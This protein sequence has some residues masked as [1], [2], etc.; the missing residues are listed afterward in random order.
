MSIA[1][2]EVA[3]P[4]AQAL[5]SIAKSK[6][7]TDELNQT[8]GEFLN[9]LNE[10]SD[11]SQFLAN[12]IAEK[13]AKRGVINKVLGDGANQQ[14]KNFMMLL[15]DKGR[16]ALVQPILEEFRSLVREMN[17]TV[18]AEVISAV[19]LTD[20][21]KETVRQKVQGMTDAKSVELST[22]VDSDLI[23]GVIVK[24]GSKVLDAS[25]RGQLRRISLQ[26]GV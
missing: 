23:G 10:S 4:Y 21:Q 2:S 17:Q 25:I 19:E 14:M 26:L 8:A 7:S 3:A 13:E 18:L 11:L 5:L 22:Q 1:T 15:V 12:P 24:I 9:L 20:E 6:N 16:I